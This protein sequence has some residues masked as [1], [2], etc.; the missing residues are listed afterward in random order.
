MV[1]RIGK[2]VAEAIGSE[3]YEMV[4]GIDEEHLLRSSRSEI[5]ETRTALRLVFARHG[6]VE[7][8]LRLRLVV[9]ARVVA[10]SVGCKDEGGDEIKLTVGCCTL[11]I[12]CAVGLA[13]PC[14][15][16]LAVATL[17]LHVLAAPSP[18]AVE[19]VLLVQLHS[20]HKAV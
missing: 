15:V 4:V 9:D 19:D 13:T 8:A 2:A 1:G 7:N 16:A 18:D 14:E 20:N 12:A 17:V 6:A 10:P 11:G 3:C 5:P